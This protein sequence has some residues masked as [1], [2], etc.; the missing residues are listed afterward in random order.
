MASLVTD[1]QELDVEHNNNISLDNRPSVTD[2]INTIINSIHLNNIRRPINT[3]YYESMELDSLLNNL[4][5]IV[6][7]NSSNSSNN[8]SNSSN[9][10]N[11]SNNNDILR[12]LEDS[13]EEEN[14]NNEQI[15]QTIYNNKINSL[16]TKKIDTE[17]KCTICL[18]LIEKNTTIY[19]FLF[20]T[21]QVS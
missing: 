2:T 10:S 8:S 13:F 16:N 3:N 12:I 19:K 4:H 9:G 1:M 7:N 11:G 15:D 5:T 17:G 20:C 6:N 14:G 21:F 18:E